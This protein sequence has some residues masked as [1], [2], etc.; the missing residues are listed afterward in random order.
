MGVVHGHKI[1]RQIRGHGMKID[2]GGHAKLVG[3]NTRERRWWLWLDGQVKDS[4]RHSWGLNADQP[5]DDE[6]VNSGRRREGKREREGKDVKEGNRQG[7][8]EKEKRKGKCA[9][10]K[11]EGTTQPRCRGIYLRK[12]PCQM[13]RDKKDRQARK[14]DSTGYSKGRLSNC[15]WSRQPGSLYDPPSQ[16]GPCSHRF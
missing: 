11:T 4:G 10:V 13:G 3:E 14:G 1:K 9:R 7:R 15:S 2:G 5:E 12:S 16:D 6:D 8:G